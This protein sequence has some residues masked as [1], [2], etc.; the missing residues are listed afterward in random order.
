[1]IHV[2]V[3][4][5]YL[6]KYKTFMNTFLGDSGSAILVNLTHQVGYV[7]F[8]SMVCGDGSAPAV[9][10]RLEEPSIR[11]FVRKISGV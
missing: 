11:E 1:M 5:H 9:Y 4:D 3:R 7:S 8:G 6:P 10:G 2:M